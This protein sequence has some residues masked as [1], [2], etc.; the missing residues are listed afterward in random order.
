M[1]TEK[2]DIKSFL[3]NGKSISNVLAMLSVVEF[4]LNLPNF[5][6]LN[7]NLY[8]FSKIYVQLCAFE[9]IYTQVKNG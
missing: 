2:C 8:Y 3:K 6:K 9:Y 5:R 4:T 1:N 7:Q